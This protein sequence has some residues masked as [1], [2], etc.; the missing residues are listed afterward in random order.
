[1]TDA[2]DAAPTGPGLLPL[3]IAEAEVVIGH[4]GLASQEPGSLAAIKL[5]VAHALHAIDP[6]LVLDGPGYGYG[7]K[8]AAVEAVRHIEM[9]GAEPGASANVRTHAPHVAATAANTVRRADAMVALAQQL[10]TT[11]SINDAAALLQRLSAESEAVLFGRDMDGDGRVGWEAGE[12][13]LRQSSQHMT[14]MKRGEGLT[15]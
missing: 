15:N 1:M 4:V 11:N 10:L 13:G 2:F 14:L 3:A 6:T 9:A 12:G 7:L 8:Q 5:H